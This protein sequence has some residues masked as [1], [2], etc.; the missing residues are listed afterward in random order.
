MTGSPEAESANLTSNPGTSMSS[1][2]ATM[3]SQADDAAL[4]TSTDARVISLNLN[5]CLRLTYRRSTSRLSPF[6]PSSEQRIIT[7]P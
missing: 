3:S 5:V 7:P 6:T 2:T 4:K 1:H